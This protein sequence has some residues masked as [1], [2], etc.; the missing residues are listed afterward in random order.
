MQNSL[1]KDDTFLTWARNREAA[2]QARLSGKD[3]PWSTDPII[4]DYRFCNVSREDD[5][6]TVEIDRLIRKPLDSAPSEV[7]FMA[8][9]LAR[10]INWPDTLQELVD[11]GAI[12]T[13]GVNLLAVQSIVAERMAADKLTYSSAYMVRSKPVHEEPFRG[14]GKISYICTV[15]KSTTLPKA[16]TRRE[17]V[18]E[19][20]EQYSFGQFMSGQ[21]AADLAYTH[22]LY[23]APDHRT[24]APFGPGALRGMNI[25]MGRSI[26]SRIDEKTYLAC[27]TEQMERIEEAGIMPPGRLTLHDVASN[28]NCETFKYCRI[29]NGGSGRMYYAR[30]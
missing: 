9:C 1:I 4:K 20:S 15:L 13:S 22:I 8:V 16:R 2:R 12:D 17:F 26:D 7:M 29:R 11:K 19:L 21:V 25:T 27:G 14:Y 10:F 18:H 24:W 30:D 3:W 23:D 6:G 5:H 28:V